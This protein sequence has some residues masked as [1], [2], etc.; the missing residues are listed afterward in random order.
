MSSPNAALD[1]QRSYGC[2]SGDGRPYDVVLVDVKDATTQ[3]LCI[4][5][6]LNLAM[7]IA[8]AITNPDDPDV[9]MVLTSSAAQTGDQVPGPRPRRGRRNAPVNS[10]DPD[11]FAAFDSGVFEE[12]SSGE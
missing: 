5:C 1:E 12:E 11:I 3:F 10:E 8:Q 4:P 7:S 2:S 6:L 9:Q